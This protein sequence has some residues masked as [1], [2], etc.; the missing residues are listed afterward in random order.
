MSKNI[1]RQK[2]KSNYTIVPNEMLNDKRLSWKAKGMLAYLLS[3]PDTWEVYVAHI[4]TIS[5]DGNDSTSSGLNELIEFKYVWRKPR[6]GNEPGGW[7]Y[8]VY[9]EPHLENPFRQ[10]DSPTR[11]F[12]DSGKPATSKETEE[13]VITKKERKQKPVDS[14]FLTELQKLNPEKDVE[15][16]AQNAQSWLLAHPDRKY[17]RAFLTAWVIRSKNTIKPERF[18]NF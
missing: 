15:R 11:D 4:R 12:P 16:E 7:E 13:E 9:D 5:T 2:R 1:Y 8:Y 3:L 6:S 10:G 17:T 18:A 14:T